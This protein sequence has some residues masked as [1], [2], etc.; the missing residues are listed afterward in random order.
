MCLRKFKKDNGKVSFGL[1]LYLVKNKTE[2]GFLQI[3]WYL[4]GSVRIAD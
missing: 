1:K 3:S 2:E 4:F